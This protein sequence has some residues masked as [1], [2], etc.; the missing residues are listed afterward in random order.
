MLEHHGDT[1]MYQ[2]PSI[3]S[4]HS[5]IEIEIKKRDHVYLEVILFF[6]GNI[7]IYTRSY[8]HTYQPWK[9]N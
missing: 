8:A 1:L 6:S 9:G 2:S 4:V 3:D 7:T 5:Y